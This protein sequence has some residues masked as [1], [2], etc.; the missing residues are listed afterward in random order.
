MKTSINKELTLPFDCNEAFKYMVNPEKMLLFTGS[1]LIP[2]IKGI[3]D[4]NEISGLGHKYK[5]INTDDSVHFEDV[6]DYI[7]GQLYKIRI[8]GFTGKSQTI[9]KEIYETLVFRKVSEVK[10]IVYRTFEL[11][12]QTKFLSKIICKY[13]IT[14]AF[15]KAIDKNHDNI[16]KDL[17]RVYTI[18]ES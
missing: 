9:L 12:P 14:P 6:I 8:Y 5:I 16:K 4:I 17:S 3:I 18:N 2:G 1:K 15:N 7:P 11:I 13:V 10:T